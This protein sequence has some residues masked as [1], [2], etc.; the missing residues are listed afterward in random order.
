MKFTI[1]D[2]VEGTEH[3]GN[4]TKKICGWANEI[5]KDEDGLLILDIQCD[6]KWCGFRGNY[7][8]ERLGEI[9][10]IEKQKPRPSFNK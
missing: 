6:D 10:L 2:Y 3:Y 7:I 5:K 1:G 4:T 8:Y 9:K